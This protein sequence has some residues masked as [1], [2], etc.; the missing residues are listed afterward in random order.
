MAEIPRPAEVYVK[1]INK[2]VPF[3]DGAEVKGLEEHYV[4][5]PDGRPK[6]PLVKCP[7]R[8]GYVIV[9]STIPVPTAKVR[10]GDPNDDNP[11]KCFKVWK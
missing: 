3:A 9:V 2:K 4:I 8:T 5:G 7:I 11:D 6:Q 1:S 10:C